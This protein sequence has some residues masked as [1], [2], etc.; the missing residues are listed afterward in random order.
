MSTV[1]DNTDAGKRTI[2]DMLD[3]TRYDEITRHADLAQN[4]WNSLYLAAQRGDDRTLRL[5][6]HQLSG[7]TRAVFHLVK[8]LGQDSP[9]E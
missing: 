7:L 9:D 8:R 1:T 3:L 5:H 4:L 6:C 2:T